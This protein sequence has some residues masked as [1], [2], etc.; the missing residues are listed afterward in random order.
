MSLGLD[1]SFGLDD[2]LGCSIL[3]LMGLVTAIILA[4]VWWFQLMER[5]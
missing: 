3:A 2:G 5:P 1:P 4:L